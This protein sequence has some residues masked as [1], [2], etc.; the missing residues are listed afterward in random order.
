MNGQFGKRTRSTWV[1]IAV[2]VMVAIVV[3]AVVRTSRSS[4]EADESA[5]AAVIVDFEAAQARA[6][7]IPADAASEVQ[8]RL[9]ELDDKSGREV[10]DAGKSPVG[11]L[12]EAAR[13]TLNKEQNAY[14]NLCS[15]AYQSRHSR[16][17]KA[18]DATEI[19]LYNNP[20]RPLLLEEQHKVLAVH[21]M[22]LAT[23]RATAWVYSWSGD[24]TTAGKGAQ[25][26]VVDEYT[27][28]FEDE[29]WRI[30][31]RT[32]IGTMFPTL[33]ASGERVSED[34][35]P[36]SPHNDV[37]SIEQDGGSSLYPGSR[38]PV[39]PLL[40]LEAKALAGK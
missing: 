33:D 8:A 14:L 26:W 32:P 24:V 36:Y 4:A 9:L 1:I 38:V 22:E 37:G 21:V 19:G 6:I 2:V 25:N 35:G 11:I 12:P 13:A 34:W 10:V 7:A 29:Q 23:A 39:A 16:D 20:Q 5:I 27:L 17:E 18:A 31:R 15:T 28:V 40:S 3:P 30:D